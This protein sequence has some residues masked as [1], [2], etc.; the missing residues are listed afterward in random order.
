MAATTTAATSS[1]AKAVAEAQP[2]ETKRSWGDEAGAE[3]DRPAPTSD[4]KSV[5]A[6]NLEALAM[7]ET[8]KKANN[9]LDDP[10]DSN[11]KSVLSLSL[12]LEKFSCLLGL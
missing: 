1:V 8:K 5:S 12:S 6:L 4:D 7:D 2:Q 11:I 10:D 9:F 3:L